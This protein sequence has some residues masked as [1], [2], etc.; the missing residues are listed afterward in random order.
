MNKMLKKKKTPDK[1][2]FFPWIT[3]E[4]FCCWN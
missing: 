2:S 4:D 1:K 3:L